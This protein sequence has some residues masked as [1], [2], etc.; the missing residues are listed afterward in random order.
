MSKFQQNEGLYRKTESPVIESVRHTEGLYR[1]T[2]VAK[3]ESSELTVEDEQAI[4]S[5]EKLPE[6]KKPLKE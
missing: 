5:M 3:V 1:K 2:K 4:K 6:G